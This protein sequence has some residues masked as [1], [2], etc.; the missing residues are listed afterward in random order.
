MKRN[1]SRTVA[2]LGLCTALALILAYVEILIQ[3][4]I[5]S[6]PGIK[7]G[8]PNI[9][10]IFLLYRRGAASASAVSFVRI[11]LVS[12]LF[13]N[14]MA[15]LY[16]LSGGVL[17]LLVMILLRRANWLSAVGVSVAGGVMHNVGQI[18]M[19]MLLLETAELGYYLVV[20]TVT[21]IIAGVFVGL[22][23]SLL[24][25]HVPNKLRF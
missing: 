20:L 16:S 23:G 18:L 10:I 12:M 21:G 9:I 15:M 1:R 14:M 17:S 24:V 3:P 13:G 2:F 7:M 19:A 11:L 5:P 8:L 4:L 22:C 25:K 6:I